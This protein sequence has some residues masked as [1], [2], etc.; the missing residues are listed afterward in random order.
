MQGID[1]CLPSQT[2]VVYSE[3]DIFLH[4][5]IMLRPCVDIVESENFGIGHKKILVG[6]L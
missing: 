6:D 4:L 5:T 1:V 3:D 2:A